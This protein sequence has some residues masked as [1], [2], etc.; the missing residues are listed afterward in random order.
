MLTRVSR[1]GPHFLGVKVKISQE[2]AIDDEH[3]VVRRP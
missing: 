1:N 3:W 2:R